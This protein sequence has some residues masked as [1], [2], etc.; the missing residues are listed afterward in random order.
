VG[1]C[2]SNHT[3]L[4]QWLLQLNDFAVHVASHLPV[5]LGDLGALMHIHVEPL[6]ELGRRCN[7]QL[8]FLLQQSQQQQQQLGQQQTA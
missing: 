8:G 2:V 4:Q 3:E 1:W 7:Q 6:L 5:N